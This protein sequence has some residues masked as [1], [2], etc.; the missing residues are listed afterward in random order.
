[1]TLFALKINSLTTAIPKD[2]FSSMFIDN[3]LMAYS[4]HD[5]K[6]LEG[7]LQRTVDTITQWAD[8]NEFRFSLTKTKAM[9]FYSKSQ[10][11]YSIHI[12][13]KKHKIPMTR[14]AKL[15]G[16]HWDS[17]LS[18]RWHV[19]IVKTK[20]MR[21]LN[22]LRSLTAVTWGADS[23]TLTKLYRAV[24]R[25]KI[26]YGSIVYG[27]ASKTVLAVLDGVINEALRISFGAFKSHR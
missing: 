1:M 8:K 12:S 18:W 10:P 9:Q 3:L 6:Q 15:L 22:L 20:C 11:A 4:L 5:H 2:V 24:I 7:K 25:P 26:Y 17:K 13:M 16:L 21:D 27:S 14:I 19:T 23:E